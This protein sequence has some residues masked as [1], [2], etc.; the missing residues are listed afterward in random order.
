MTHPRILSPAENAAITAQCI[1]RVYDE[2][3][4]EDAGRPIRPGTPAT[5]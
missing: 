4:R 3:D 2:H 5:N 1:R